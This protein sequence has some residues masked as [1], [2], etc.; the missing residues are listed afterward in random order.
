M[1]APELRLTLAD[2]QLLA[3]Y[4]RVVRYGADE[5]VQYA[6]EVPAVMTFLVAGSVRLTVIDEVG[7]VV[8]VTTLHQGSFLGITA[9][10]RQPNLAG[11]YALD[12]VTAVE[13]ERE[14]LEKIVMNKPMLLQDL[15]RIIDERQS[16]ARRVTR[17]E[18]V[19]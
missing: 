11:A 7:D 14:H 2:Q 3:P 17:R 9:L 5:I 8:P 19:G 15:G 13:I 18:R 12:E 16:T 1:V 10:T 6:G 4:A